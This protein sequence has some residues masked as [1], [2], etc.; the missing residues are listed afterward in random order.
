MVRTTCGGNLYARTSKRINTAMALTFTWKFSLLTSTPA[1]RY[2]MSM[3]ISG[4]L[5][6]LEYTGKSSSL[7]SLDVTGML[8]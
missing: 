4:M 1:N 5:M 6:L 7:L 3:L 8:I 2:P